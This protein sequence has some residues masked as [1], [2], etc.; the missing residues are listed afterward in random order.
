[1]IFGR[2]EVE[3]PPSQPRAFLF[4]R[5]SPFR[6]L[7]SGAS[8]ARPSRRNTPA[9][10]ERLEERAELAARNSPTSSDAHRWEQ[11]RLDVAVDGSTT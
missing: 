4:L 8:W 6:L 1:M 2:V 7:S 11:T 5:G 10:F 9:L 3:V